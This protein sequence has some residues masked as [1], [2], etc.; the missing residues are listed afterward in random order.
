MY[1]TRSP[2]YQLNCLTRPIQSSLIMGGVFT[3]IDVFQGAPFTPRAVLTNVGGL[4]LYHIIQCPMEAI[5][6]RPSA[7]HNVLS[8]ATLGYVGVA[9]GRLGIPLIDVHTLMYR[10]PSVSPPMAGAVVYGSIAGLLATLG[11]KPF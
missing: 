1:G 11:N 4:Y 3:A 8:G 5:H 6:G 10:F 9:A 2:Q 7:W